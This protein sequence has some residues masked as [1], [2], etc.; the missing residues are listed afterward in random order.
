MRLNQAFDLLHEK[1]V[2]VFGFDSRCYRGG[3]GA[4]FEILEK[5]WKM[6]VIVDDV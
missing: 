3:S 2:G 1:R 4:R 6:V 5:I